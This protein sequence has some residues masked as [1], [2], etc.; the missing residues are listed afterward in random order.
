MHKYI[1]PHLTLIRL[2]TSG[3]LLSGSMKVNDGSYKFNDGNNE[4]DW[5]STQRENNAPTSIWEE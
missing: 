1:P 3:H 4:S 5:L 2:E